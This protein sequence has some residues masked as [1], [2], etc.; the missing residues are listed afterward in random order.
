MAPLP[1]CIPISRSSWTFNQFLFSNW[2]NPP[3]LRGWTET[4]VREIPCKSSLQATLYRTS[5]SPVYYPGCL[6]GA[7]TNVR[8]R[9]YEALLLSSL[10]TIAGRRGVVAGCASESMANIGNHMRGSPNS[11]S[12][13]KL[14]SESPLAPHRR[15]RGC[16]RALR[17]YV[18]FAPFNINWHSLEPHPALNETKRLRVVHM[19]IWQQT[20]SRPMEPELVVSTTANPSPSLLLPCTPLKTIKTFHVSIVCCRAVFVARLVSKA[21]LFM[22]LAFSCPWTLPCLAWSACFIYKRFSRFE[23]LNR[24]IRW[25]TD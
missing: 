5:M 2:H 17:L 10:F 15:G 8:I 16:R 24:A 7:S 19:L 4:G 14:L 9:H 3:T 6:L 23:M 20:L 25:L 21:F 22:C 12:I 18:Y 13:Y 1:G 11:L